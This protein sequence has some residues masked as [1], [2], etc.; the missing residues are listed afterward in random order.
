MAEVALK[1][2]EEQLQCSICLETY[3]DPKL[4][5]CNHVYCQKCL[6]KLV[7]RD[8]Q[9]QLS[10]PCPICRQATPVPA[11]GVEVSNQ[12]STLITSL[13]FKTLSKRV[14]TFQPLVLGRGQCL[15]TGVRACIVAW[16]II[17]NLS[18]TATHARIT[19][20][21]SVLS[22]E[23]SIAATTMKC[24]RKPFRDKN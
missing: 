2:L 7:I 13:S 1:K 23:A 10:L 3:T 17:G 11:S 9:G 14:V 24:L 6:V 4:L 16:S 20:V 18:F 15:K 22:K 19:S 12:L 8:Q 5:Q 21:S